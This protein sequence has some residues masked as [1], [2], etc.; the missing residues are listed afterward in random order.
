MPGKRC[1]ALQ[2]AQD[3]TSAAGQAALKQRLRLAAAETQAAELSAERDA[4]VSNIVQLRG[5]RDALRATL[6]QNEQ[7]HQAL[8]QNAK[9]HAALQQQIDAQVTTRRLSK[10]HASAAAHCKHDTWIRY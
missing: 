8:E 2:F 10:L 4:A 1:G 7:H 3:D 6:Q 5:E 9:Q